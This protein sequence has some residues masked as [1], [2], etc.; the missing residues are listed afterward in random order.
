MKQEF[1]VVAFLP[2][3]NNKVT[4]VER[5]FADT[6]AAYRWIR[7]NGE[8]DIWYQPA[9]LKGRL[10]RPQREIKRSLEYG[11]EQGE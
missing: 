1:V 11:E 5:G 6:A 10:A 7:D 2:E 8:L 9:V 4:V 3:D